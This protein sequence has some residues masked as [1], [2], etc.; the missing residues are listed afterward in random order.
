MCR[1]SA[2][3][4]VVL[5]MHASIDVLAAQGPSA[6]NLPITDL[7]TNQ[8]VGNV[9]TVFRSALTICVTDVLAPGALYAQVATGTTGRDNQH[10]TGL[11]PA[12]TGV[13]PLQ[14][15]YLQATLAC[16]APLAATA[17]AAIQQ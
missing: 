13:V 7:A 3:S 16:A 11:L 1:A 6:V 14:C 4:H 2:T 10:L 9:T 5:V 15:V 8:T 17:A 12:G